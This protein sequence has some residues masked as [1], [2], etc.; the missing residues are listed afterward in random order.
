MNSE[1]DKDYTSMSSDDSEKDSP[2]S[3]RAAKSA[4]SKRKDALGLEEFGSNNGKRIKE[5]TIC[6]I[7][8]KVSQWRKLYSGVQKNG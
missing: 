3:R 1:K 8:H 4:T 5:R 2:K 7:I 6:D